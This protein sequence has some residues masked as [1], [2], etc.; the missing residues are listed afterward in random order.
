M[1]SQKKRLKYEKLCFTRFC[2][3]QQCRL[4]SDF[5][6][7]QKNRLQVSKH[8]PGSPPRLAMSMKQVPKSFSVTTLEMKR[9][10][11]PI[12]EDAMSF[13]ELILFSLF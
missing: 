3:L 9:H 4:G 8:S 11:H 6:V 13:L 10:N 5:A 12:F 2:T 7:S 1:Y